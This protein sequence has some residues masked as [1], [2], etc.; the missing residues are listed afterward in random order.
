MPEI[1]LIDDDNVDK[2]SG[3]EMRCQTVKNMVAQS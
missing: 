1:F 3:E 2:N